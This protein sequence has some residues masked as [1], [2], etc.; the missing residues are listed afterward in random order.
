MIEIDYLN[1]H[2]MVE[3]V[4]L[5]WSIPMDRALFLCDENGATLHQMSAGIHAPGYE[6]SAYVRWAGFR[7]F[8]SLL[9][10]ADL[11]SREISGV[12]ELSR[13]APLPVFPG[14]AGF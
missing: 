6:F 10:L 7:A 8:E 5:E 1:P 9:P 2:G 14:S 12:I 13:E 4:V 3:L 11:D